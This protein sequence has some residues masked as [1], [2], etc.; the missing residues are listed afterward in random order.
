[1]QSDHSGPQE[2]DQRP[3]TDLQPRHEIWARIS[4]HASL[5]GAILFILLIALFVF[6]ITRQY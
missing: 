4:S 5:I 6:W 3:E 2:G 1:M